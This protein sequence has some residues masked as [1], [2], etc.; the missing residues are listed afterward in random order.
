MNKFQNKL[1]HTICKKKE[2]EAIIFLEI[3]MVQLD[4]F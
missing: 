3:Y 2:V 1:Q 4:N